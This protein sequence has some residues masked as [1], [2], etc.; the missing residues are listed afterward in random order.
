MSEPTISVFEGL[1]SGVVGY[2]DGSVTL[3]AGVITQLFGANQ[4]RKGYKIQA[5]SDDVYINEDG[6]S[7][8]STDPASFI[9]YEGDMYESQ[10][11]GATP[12]A[13]SVLSLAGT[14]VFAAQW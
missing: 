8:S 13:I 7:A 4:Y 1:P 3:V 2:T 12:N 11:S 14:I 5:R 10:L 9:L 6:G